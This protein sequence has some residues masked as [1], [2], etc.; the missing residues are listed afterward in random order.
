MKRS[1]VSWLACVF[2]VVVATSGCIG[3]P[4]G[5]SEE[6]LGSTTRDGVAAV[7]HAPP[8]NP[9]NSH[10]IVVG[11][12]AVRAHVAHGDTVGPCPGDL[13]CTPIVIDDFERPDST[14]L[15]GPQVPAGATWTE[16][17]TSLDLE[18]GALVHGPGSAG[19]AHVSQGGNLGYDG[20]RVR[21][22]VRFGDVD[23]VVGDNFRAWFNG[24]ATSISGGVGFAVRTRDDELAITRSATDP[25]PV[26]AVSLNHLLTVDT[27]YYLEF[28]VD[29]T[30]AR[31]ELREDSYEG[32]LLTF[33]ETDALPQTE[34]LGESFYVFLSSDGGRT[35]SMLE[36]A[37]ERCTP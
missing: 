21:T 9:S 36:V 27:N 6:S 8:G 13:F 10:T 2:G 20:I 12:P 15:G 16:L 17:G 1:E 18:G 22:A 37:L 23:R 7:C 32:P 5:W 30:H 35:P 31:L 24:S 19:Y 34:L 3:G 14:S 4:E 28:F 26:A 25:T 11:V 29:G 33:V